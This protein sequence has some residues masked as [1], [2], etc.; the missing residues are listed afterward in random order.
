M[1]K[2][3]QNKKNIRYVKLTEQLLFK[4]ALPRNNMQ[5]RNG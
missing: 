5:D 4:N 1:Y 3:M 2:Q